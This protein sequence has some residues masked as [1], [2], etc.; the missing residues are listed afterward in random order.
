MRILLT[1]DDGIHAEGLLHLARVASEF[2]EVKICAPD[3]ERSAC[4]HGMTLR[5]PLRASRMEVEGGF[6]AYAVNG[7]PVD[8]V[9]VGLTIAY[10][11]G[12]DLVLSGINNGPNLGFDITYSGTVG[13]AMEGAINGIR[14]VALSMFTVA[15]EAPLHFET[16]VEWFRENWNLISAAPLPPRTFLNINVPS[17]ASVELRGTR[18]TKMGG[19]VYQDRVEERQDPWGRSYFWQGGTVIMSPTG[20]GTDIDAVSEGF[21][22]VTPVTLDWTARDAFDSLESSLLQR[23]GTQSTRQ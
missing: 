23:R 3:R 19:R 14:S 1:N 2:G 8:C 13:G 16:L 21:V 15:Y 10:P 22:S 6:E 12:C 9:N 7:L 11:N 17:I 18:V 20:E 5:D 4:S